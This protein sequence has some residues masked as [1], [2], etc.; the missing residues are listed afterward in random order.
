MCEYCI[1]TLM[2]LRLLFALLIRLNLYT[3]KCVNAID[4]NLIKKLLRQSLMDWTL[5]IYQENK[6]FKPGFL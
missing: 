6:I 3:I 5:C 4:H 2:A 1:T